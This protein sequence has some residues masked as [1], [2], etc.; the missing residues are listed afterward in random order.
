MFVMYPRL[1]SFDNYP[2]QGIHDRVKKATE[3]F[4]LPFVDLLPRYSQHNPLDLM[5]PQYK[6]NDPV[7]PGRFGNRLAAEETMKWLMNSDLAKD[8]LVSHH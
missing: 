3:K 7:H 1:E 8:R 4:E 2:S 6:G 5:V